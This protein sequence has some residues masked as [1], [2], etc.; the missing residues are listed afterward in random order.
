MSERED[1]PLGYRCRMPERRLESGELLAI[2]TE[3]TVG[4]TRDT[5]G[6]DLARELTTLGVQVGRLVA[7]PDELAAVTDAFAQALT[8]ADLVVSTGGL[9]PTPDDLTREAIAAVFGETPEVDRDLEAWLRELFQ[10]RGLVMSDANRKQAWLIA[11]ARALPNAHGTAPGWWVDASDGRVVIALP[12]PPREMRPMWR[13]HVVPSLLARGVGSDRASRTLRLTDIGESTLVELLGEE[14]LR[15]R[16]PEVATYAR[17]DAVDLRVAAVAPPG[18]EGHER[19]D[20]RELVESTVRELEHK[21][22]DHI[23]GRDEETWVDVLGARLGA[24]RLACVEIGTGGH[25]TAL[26]GSAPFVTFSE[27]LASATVFAHSDEHLEDYAIHVR[28]ISGADV[29]VA[30][31][32]SDHGGDTA[33]SIAI[34]TDAGTSRVSRIAF[35]G[36]DEGRR[37]AAVAACAELWRRLDAAPG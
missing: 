5:N 19:G 1:A 12:G 34:A 30:I 18:D 29:G 37:R 2:G 17:A 8:R 25:L 13:E 10:R 21:L 3:L 26:L 36:G 16:N 31:R 9:G 6:G 11:G 20:A 14:L 15:S 33:V 4:D 35:L 24:R 32:A 28:G 7:L 23:F 22:R 27:L